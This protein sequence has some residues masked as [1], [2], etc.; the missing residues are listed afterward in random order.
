MSIGNRLS[1]FANRYKELLNETQEQNLSWGRES[2]TDE[3][4]EII[5]EK[6]KYKFRALFE[7]EATKKKAKNNG[8]N[9]FTW[10]VDLF[11]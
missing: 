10:D 11:Y 4:R 1:R 8:I 6:T 7:E 3:E 9:P 2:L 5:W